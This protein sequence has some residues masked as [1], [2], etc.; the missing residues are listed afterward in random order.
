VSVNILL[1]DDHQIIR[2]GLAVAMAQEPDLNVIAQTGDGLSAVRLALQYA[3]DIVIADVTMP[4]LNGIEATRQITSQNPSI[5]VIVLSMH[6]ER[7]F[8]SEALLA[9][10]S[11]YV[12]K[13]SPMSELVEAIH[14]VTDGQTYLGSKVQ[15]CLIQS[16]IASVNGR[17]GFESLTPREREILQLVAE[18]KNTK[19]IA[20]TLHLS[21]KTVEG[22]RRQVME[23]LDLFSVADLTRFAIREG[24][25]TL[26]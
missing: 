7:Q 1:A 3:P 12:P 6:V 2:E 4:L 9:G 16:C 14:I 23:K 21:T 11:G 26:A 25:A 10:A 20:Y 19:E 5:K 17:R 8:V 24:V 15:G 22:H 18:G 13:D